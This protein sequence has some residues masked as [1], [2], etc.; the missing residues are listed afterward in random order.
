MP[1]AHKTPRRLGNLGDVFPLVIADC[2]HNIL[3]AEW[4]LFEACLTDACKWSTEIEF[5]G[6]LWGIAVGSVDVGHYRRI[7][8]LQ[9]ILR[10]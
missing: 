7:L 8:R 1:S 6:H 3:V 5:D 2:W 10:V 9:W 4:Q